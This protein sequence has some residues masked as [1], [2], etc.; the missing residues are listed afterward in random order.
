MEQGSQS[1][2]NLFLDRQKYPLDVCDDDTTPPRRE[3]QGE[4]CRVTSLEGALKG[5]TTEE[6]SALKAMPP[7]TTVV[8]HGL[9]SDV[10]RALN[11][12]QGTVKGEDSGRLVVSVGGDKKKFKPTNLRFKFGR[13]QTARTIVPRIHAYCNLEVKIKITR[14]HWLAISRRRRYC[15]ERAAYS[16]LV[17]RLAVPPWQQWSFRLIPRDLLAA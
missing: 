8:L 17:D 10:G 7:G 12:K 2:F 16:I 1:R 15:A 9:T 6:G 13:K 5:R 4:R 3:M 11:G 14:Q